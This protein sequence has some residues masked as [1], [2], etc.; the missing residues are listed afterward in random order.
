MT[1][2]AVVIPVFTAY[3]QYQKFMLA[4]HPP[5]DTQTWKENFA[6]ILA[7]YVSVIF[8]AVFAVLAKIKAE[9]ILEEIE[10]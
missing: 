2:T 4:G 7:L 5:S 10:E 6:Y 8:A 9:N 3:Q 1:V